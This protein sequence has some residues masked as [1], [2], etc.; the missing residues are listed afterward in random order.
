M[1]PLPSP[2]VEDVAIDCVRPD[3]TN[4]RRH[5]TNKGPPDPPTDAA[6]T[7]DQRLAIPERI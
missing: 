6:P 1:T 4:P 2:A 3:P 7:A 5:P